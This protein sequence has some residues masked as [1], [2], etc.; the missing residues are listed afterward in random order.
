M[1]ALILGSNFEALSI[2]DTFT[3][4]IWTDRY[5]GC[6]DFEVYLPVSGATVDLLTKGNYLV[7]KK[8]DRLMI[9]E[10][11]A[12]DTDPE[13]GACITVTG[14]SLESILER[15]VIWGQVVLS[16]SFQNGIQ[17]LLN[18]NVIS[19]SITARQI[20]NFT[21][22]ASADPAITGLTIETQFF[23][24]N[25]YDAIFALCEERGIGFKVLPAGAGGFT[26][27][28]YSGTDRSYEQSTVPWVVFSPKFDNLLSSNYFESARGYKNVALSAGEGDGSARVLGEAIAD[29][30]AS[31]LN[32]L[33]M[34]VDSASISK[35]T[36][37]GTLTSQ[38]YL[39]QLIEKGK[40]ALA[41]TYVTESFEG[42]VEASKQFVYNKDFYIGDIVQIVNDYGKQA[43]SRV[44]EIVQSQDVENGET[45]VPT[46]TA[47]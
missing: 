8:S 15:R 13:D 10:D 19:P 39:N 46:F 40:E 35:T 5:C 18:Q 9:I 20:P 7:T 2:L 44:S 45:M 42:E 29:T 4:F 30:G 11:I 25:L 43:R 12:I 47:T 17:T 27:E 16:G 1:E 3:S 28:L 33:E 23:G 31:G 14:R 32:R 22:K 36:S 38:Q 24:N 21:F 6:G 34:F 41:E 37:G 26:F